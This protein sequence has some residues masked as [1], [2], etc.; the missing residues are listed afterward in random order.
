MNI[1]VAG[2]HGSIGSAVIPRLI[3]CGH[4]VFRLVRSTPKPSEIY[5]DP[6][7][8]KIDAADLEGFD[9]VISLATVRWPFRWTSML[10]KQALEALRNHK[11]EQDRLIDSVGRDWTDL[12]LVFPSGAA[13]PL[14]A[15]NIRR[16]FR[17][18][19]AVSGLP[20]IR[21][22]DLRHTAA[23]LMFNHGIPVLIV[24]KR[25]GHSKPS[26]TLDVYGHLIP[27]K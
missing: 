14:T 26:I 18:L 6:D 20:K 21:F 2:P 10:G 9:G 11:G 27:S 15:S 24:S 3:E 19:L 12:N 17:K 4:E 1:L 7:A 23:S 22:H 25:P 13:T 8:G 16:D 5:W